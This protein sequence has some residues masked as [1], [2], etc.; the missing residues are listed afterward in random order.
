[1]D[2]ARR[3]ATIAGAARDGGRRRVVGAGGAGKTHLLEQVAAALEGTPVMRWNPAVEPEPGPGGGVLLADDVHLA[4]PGS[5]RALLR[6]DGGVVAAHRPAERAAEQVLDA[7]DGGPLVLEP[8]RADEVRAMLE[9]VWDAPPDMAIVDRVLTATGGS[10]RL[11]TAVAGTTPVTDVTGSATLD[12]IVRSERQRLGATE[13]ALLDAAAVL[14]DLDLSLVAAAADL[15]VNTAAIAAEHLAGAGLA[16]DAGARLVPIVATTVRQLVPASAVTDI[17]ERAAAAAVRL[18]HDLV[19]IAGHILTTGVSS[20]GTTACLLGAA[21]QVLDD[22]PGQAQAWIESAGRGGAASGDIAALRALVGFR[23]GDVPATVAAVDE[24]LRT[25]P[26]WRDAPVRCD[27]VEAG[28]VMLARR[29]A[30]ERSAALAS[31]IGPREGNAVALAAT[32]RLAIGDAQG[33]R[34]TVA[35]AEAAPAPGLRASAATTL[36]R[37][38]VTSLAADA[39]RALPALLDAARLYELAAPSVTLPITPHAL[40]ATVA[41]HLWEFDVASQVLAEPGALPGVQRTTGEHLLQAWIA[42]RRGDWVGASATVEQ[43]RAAGRL[44][45]RDAL[46]ACAIEAGTA[47]RRGDLAAM[48]SAWRAARTLLLRQ[49]PD[50]L[51]VQPI[52][53]LLITGARLGDRGTVRMGVAGIHRL[54]ER[55]GHA[56]LWTLP[57]LWDELHVAVAVDDLEGARSAARTAEALADR[58]GRAAVVTRAGVC[59]VEALDGMADAQRIREAASGLA[60]VGLVWEASRLAGAA[61]IRMSDGATMRDLLQFARGLTAERTPQL[62][63]GASD[64]SPRERDVATHLLAGLTYREIGGQLYIAPKTVEHH[65]ARIRRKLGVKSRAELL[66]ALR[67]HVA[68][69]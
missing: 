4:A 49:I 63:A 17:V 16:V 34:A 62:D 29:G 36:A 60:D 15:R 59:W 41:C 25:D 61:A 1:M 50:L 48:D 66:V 8:L 26:H 43:I 10:P 42:L 46:L 31:A 5:L 44:D 57:V 9:D 22:D 32:A 30:W 39:A 27:A 56:P 54:L 64:L 69:A 28:A 40:A 14:P 18:G 38:L 7:F 35:A 52:S 58:G 37:G 55:A 3:A 21:R 11:V 20:A 12:E 51:I 45:P 67:R 33:L 6:W 24:L 65:V 13:R 19:G 53:E 2:D 68:I 23:Q 47:R